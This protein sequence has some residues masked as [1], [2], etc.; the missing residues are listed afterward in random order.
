MTVKTLEYMMEVNTTN[1]SSI[2]VAMVTTGEPLKQKTKRGLWVCIY[3]KNLILSSIFD[4]DFNI[5]YCIAFCR[6]TNAKSN[7]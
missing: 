1:K 5:L 7:F 6:N 3:F 2:P 4:F